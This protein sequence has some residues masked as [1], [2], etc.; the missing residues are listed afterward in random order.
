MASK[1]FKMVRNSIFQ[2]FKFYE[3][4]IR[5]IL[6]EITPGKDRDATYLRFRF[7]PCTDTI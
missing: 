5:Y 2:K 7:A 4:G 3:F 6:R 1:P